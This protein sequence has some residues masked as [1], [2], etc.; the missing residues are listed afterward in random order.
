MVFF[1]KFKQFYDEETLGEQT[2]EAVVTVFQKAQKAR[3]YEDPHESLASTWLHR[4]ELMGHDVRNSDMVMGALSETYLPACIRPPLCAR[5]L[6]LYFLYK[7]NPQII[8][9]YPKFAEEYN[10][11]M[12][13]V[14][15]ALEDGSI[16]DLYRKYNPRMAAEAD[17]ET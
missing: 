5:T 1:D 15:Q 13:P 16:D 8:A 11:L 7:E 6:G 12:G 9:K 2:I 10:A 3:P 14:F 4:M 17:K